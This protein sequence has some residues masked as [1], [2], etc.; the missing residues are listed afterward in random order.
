MD[1][2]TAKL[3]ESLA[4]KL[5]TTS[6]YLWGVKTDY[7]FNEDMWNRGCIEQAMDIYAKQECLAFERF[8]VKGYIYEKANG[9]WYNIEKQHEGAEAFD[10]EELYNL[11]LQSK[12]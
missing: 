6:E 5:G 4:Q 12:L 1:D 9:F 11:Y 10:R 7:D 8:L 2:K 3:I